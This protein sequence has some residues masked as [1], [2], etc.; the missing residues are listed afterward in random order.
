MKYLFPIFCAIF[1]SCSFQPNNSNGIVVLK[2]AK[3]TLTLGIIDSYH[4]IKDF[5]SYQIGDT[6]FLN[7]NSIH[8]IDK[9]TEPILINVPSHIR[10]VKIQNDRIISIDSVAYYGRDTR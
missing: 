3:N 7:V 9:R 8:S 5:S 4:V 6:L 2:T 10:M 1:S